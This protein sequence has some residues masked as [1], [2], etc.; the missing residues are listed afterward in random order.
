M[1]WQALLFPTLVDLFIIGSALGFAVYVWR[2]APMVGSPWARHLLILG[3]ALVAAYF[4]I[5]LLL[6]WLVLP[7]QDQA[8]N[9]A[10][11]DFVTHTVRAPISLAFMIVTLLGFYLTVRDMSRT[12]RQAED[13]SAQLADTLKALPDGLL[14][15]DAS[16]TITSANPT[17]EAMF[18]GNKGESVVGHNAAEVFYEHEAG[19]KLRNGRLPAIS[20]SGRRFP[21]EISCTEGRNNQQLVLVRNV[22]ETAAL[23]AQLRQ[24]QKME[25][26]GRLAGGIAHDFNNYLTVVLGEVELLDPAHPVSE[27][28]ATRIREAAERAADLT[29]QLLSFSRK[30]VLD[31]TVFDPKTAIA[32]MRGLLEN[33][34][35][36]EIT[37]DFAHENIPTH[38][39][40]DRAQFEQVIVNLSI[41]AR[42]AMPDGGKLRIN[43]GEVYLDDAY[44][45]RHPDTEPGH[46][47]RVSVTDTGSGMSADIQEHIFEPFYTTKP[48]GRGTGLGL[49]MVMGFIKQSRG[50]IEVNSA[51][52]QGTSM[53]MYLPA[54]DAPAS[55]GE[56]QAAALDNGDLGGHG[57][58]VVAEDDQAV[59]AFVTKALTQNGYTVRDFDTAFD[60]LQAIDASVDLLLT[61]IVMPHG[62]GYDLARRARENLPDLPVLYMTGYIDYA[63]VGE[64]EPAPYADTLRK[65]FSARELL[66][67][68]REHI[69]PAAREANSSRET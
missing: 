14:T 9:D 44:T 56:G 23:E 67:A 39:Q 20:L 66:I 6:H 5:D 28:S 22:T 33:L 45:A 54:T 63:S 41:N 37:L 51:E 64:D 47:V 59:R 16:L 58:V 24:S 30:Q 19:G 42:D 12:M 31:T 11:G 7:A 38:V 27:E 13:V 49:A 3:M 29:N 62:S 52:D 68:V 10:F 8:A 15:L 21:A 35:G 48:R 60:A 53:R 50:M 61:D 36:K 2:R 34:L 17:A 25:S 46:F 18:G 1:H 43:V 69:R 65:P 4:L 55:T 32:D 40:V 57:H 26:L